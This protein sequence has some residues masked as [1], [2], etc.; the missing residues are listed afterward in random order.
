MSKLAS[1][2]IYMI[3]NQYNVSYDTIRLACADAERLDIPYVMLMPNQLSTALEDGRHVR[4]ITPSGYPAGCQ[5]ISSKIA[6]LQQAQAMGADRVM[7]VPFNGLT[8]DGR[9][10]EAAQE[11]RQAAASVHIP[12]TLIVET[13]VFTREQMA[14]ICNTAICMGIRSFATSAGFDRNSIFSL[15]DPL[16]MAQFLDTTSPEAVT[17]IR[18]YAGPNAEIIALQQTL[19]EQEAAA[20][21]AAG[22]D[23]IGTCSALMLAAGS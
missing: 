19:N 2:L 23:L 17:A 6:E 9:L 18:E 7:Y 20:L 11:L 16:G 22:A 1:R 3:A 12:L 10:D 8:L 21:T 5:P 15:T 13:G 14:F 4:Y